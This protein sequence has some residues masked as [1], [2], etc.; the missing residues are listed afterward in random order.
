MIQ[1]P[2]KWAEQRL[3]KDSS[4]VIRNPRVKSMAQ[5]ERVGILFGVK[6]H[7]DANLL[8]E[9]VTY[10]KKDLGVFSVEPLIY[11][12]QKELPDF[13]ETYKSKTILKKDLD[14]WGVPKHEIV[15]WFLEKKVDILF[16]LNI[17][18]VFPLRYILAV[19]TAGLKVGLHT[20]K[21]EEFLDLMIQMEPSSNLWEQIRQM[22]HYVNQ[23]GQGN[24]KSKWSRSGSRHTV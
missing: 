4:R 12:D 6:N 7:E 18:S 10:L 24:G 23:I 5:A 3:R 2:E 21:N 11:V 20:P 1:L 22:I 13:L 16:D 9:F 17:A 14:I 8:F 19:S 15:K